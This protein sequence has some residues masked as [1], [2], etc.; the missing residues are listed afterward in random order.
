MKK[1]YNQTIQNLVNDVMENSFWLD[2]KGVYWTD[3]FC[4]DDDFR[5]PK[6]KGIFSDGTQRDRD[7]LDSFT[8]KVT[9]DS[10]RYLELYPH[11]IPYF[12][13]KNFKPSK[14]S[15]S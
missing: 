13:S 12:S 1:F 10:I 9:E 14:K 4:R 5:N 15:Y 7:N 6:F 8:K 2:A 3:Y 11:K